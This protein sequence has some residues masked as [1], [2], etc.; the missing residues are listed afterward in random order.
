MVGVVNNLST[1]TYSHNAGWTFVTKAAIESKLGPIDIVS[2]SDDFDRY[3]T[4]II[5]EGVNYKENQFNFF[6]GVQPRQIDAL[7]R[8]SNY[9]GRTYALN[10]VVDYNTLIEKRKEL[11]GHDMVFDIP[12]V[13][14][15]LNTSNKLVL[16]D[17]H[18]LSVFRPGYTISRN[19]GKTLHGFLKQGIASYIPSH[20]DELV[21]YAGNIDIRFHTHRHGR[22][23][24]FELIT[25]LEHQLRGLH[26][27]KI[28]LT[29]LLPIEPET[30]KIPGTGQYKGQNFFGTREERTEYVMLFNHMISAMASNNG[31]D[32]ISWDFDYKNFTEDY[33]EARQSV[34]LRPT[35][36][37]YADELLQTQ[38]TLL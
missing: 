8:F 30:R 23:S 1:R 21:F 14:N 6:G 32:Y 19:D 17:S 31:W 9:R 26:M 36:Y 5:N 10:T 13:V 7:K 11:R 20:V 34:H 16:G 22:D 33:M 12:K 2:N 15:L 18:S 37:K 3:D 27:R 25:E 38:P 4:L 24:I 28:T 29:H 35:S